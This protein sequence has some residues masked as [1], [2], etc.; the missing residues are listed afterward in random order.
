MKICY[1]PRYCIFVFPWIIPRS[2]WKSQKKKKRTLVNYFICPWE[3]VS[4][5]RVCFWVTFTHCTGSLIIIKISRLKHISK[6]SSEC[7]PYIYIN[8]DDNKT[9]HPLWIFIYFF[10]I[11]Y[12]FCVQINFCN[13]ME[14]SFELSYPVIVICQRWI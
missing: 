12:H 4:K 6:N 1:G 9:S 5:G 11:H 2:W 3:W 8:V 13:N 7:R 14:V 10:V